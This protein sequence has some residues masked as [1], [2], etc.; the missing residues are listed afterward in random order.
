[1]VFVM[2]FVGKTGQGLTFLFVL[3]N[4]FE[5]LGFECSKLT[6]VELQYYTQQNSE[7]LS[8]TSAGKQIMALLLQT[9]K[10]F[11]FL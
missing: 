9:F 6:R 7:I 10:I 1:M 5:N 4:E 8:Q 2:I 3:F 11:E